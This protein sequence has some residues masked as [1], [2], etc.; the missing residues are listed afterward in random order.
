MSTKWDSHQFTSFILTIIGK[1]W[2]KIIIFDI[3]V[4]KNTN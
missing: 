1:K 2:K 3:F 4:K